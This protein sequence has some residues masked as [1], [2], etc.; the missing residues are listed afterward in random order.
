MNPDFK[1]FKEPAF[2]I[3]LALIAST[4]AVGGGIM[5]WLQR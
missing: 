2:L 1:P 3:I 4:V 5:W